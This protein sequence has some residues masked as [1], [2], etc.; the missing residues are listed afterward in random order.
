[1]CCIYAL[2]SRPVVVFDIVSGRSS[3][4]HYRWAVLPGRMV[5]VDITESIVDFITHIVCGGGEELA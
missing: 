5:G 4:Y 1:M 3:E 2:Y